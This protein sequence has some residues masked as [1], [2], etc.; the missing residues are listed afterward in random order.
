MRILLVDDDPVM[1]EALQRLLETEKYVV[2]IAY[3]G[4]SGWDLIESWQY[5]LILLDVMLPK[6]DGITFC[7]RLRDRKNSVLVMLLTARDTMTDKIVGLDSGADDYVVKPFN[8]QELAARI[9]ALIRRTT[10][11]TL[12]I[13]TC[14]DLSLDPNLL[15][16][17]YQGKILQFSRKEYLI[18][19]LFLRNQKRLYS[20]RDIVDHLWEFDAEPPNESTVRSHIKN[21]RRQLESVGA[22]N[23]LETVYGQG[24]RI[25]NSFISVNN[26]SA[27]TPNQQKTVDYAVAEVWEETKYLSF[28]RLRVLEDVVK[29]LKLAKFNNDLY[30]KALQNSHK[31][32][33]SLGIFGFDKG[34]SLARKIENL[35]ESYLH[36]KSPF[37]PSYQREFLQKIEPLII[38]LH[39]ELQVPLKSQSPNQENQYMIN[40]KILVIDDD[41]QI[42]MLLRSL[43]EPLGVQLTYLSSADDFWTTLKST[44]PDFLILDI[45]MP[46]ANEGL[47]LCHSIRNNNEWNWLPIFFLTGCTDQDTL[48]QAFVLGADDL[49]TKPIRAKELLIRIK[50]RYDRIHTIVNFVKNKM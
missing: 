13:F 19:E 43:L 7:R 3:D 36:E 12:T 22:E 1:V 44:Q 14:G 10:T 28:E 17:N 4:I 49:L 15:E 31:L 35:L 41:M 2:D 16:V 47:D 25:K 42:L 5:D 38:A 40:A 23:F 27:I 26:N 39:H 34:S 46:N 32:S 50:N 30:Q 24:Y 33:G 29:S 48:Q 45:N 18:V 20:C 21:I 11:S 9:R 8:T 37:K 6:L